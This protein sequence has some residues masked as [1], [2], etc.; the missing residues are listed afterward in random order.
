MKNLTSVT[1]K[2]SL[3]VEPDNSLVSVMPTTDWRFFPFDLRGSH[4]HVQGASLKI[5]EPTYYGLSAPEALGC[6]INSPQPP[7]ANQNSKEAEMAHNINFTQTLSDL[8]LTLTA[9]EG[10]EILMNADGDLDGHGRDR[11]ALLMGV[12]N[13]L[14]ARQMEDLYAGLRNT[15]ES[16]ASEPAQFCAR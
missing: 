2:G 7:Y 4:V 5:W 15:A 11:I 16:A 12:L 13:K 3:S 10:V 9:Y 8:E 14:A 6:L 1:R